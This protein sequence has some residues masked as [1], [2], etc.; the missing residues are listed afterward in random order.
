MI[1]GRLAIITAVAASLCATVRAAPVTRVL[2]SSHHDVGSDVSRSDIDAF[3]HDFADHIAVPARDSSS[4]LTTI[5]SSSTRSLTDQDRGE[6]A[7]FLVSSRSQDDV[8]ETSIAESIRDILDPTP[9]TPSFTTSTPPEPESLLSSFHPGV[10]GGPSLASLPDPVTV[11]PEPRHL[12]FML[13]G[14][15]LLASGLLRKHIGAG[16]SGV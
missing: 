16:R 7:A 2:D 11:V 10:P 5:I 3:S 6:V 15:L 4:D 8:S 9:P 13:L 1:L 14:L 12:A